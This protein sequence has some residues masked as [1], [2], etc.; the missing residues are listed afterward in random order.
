[1]SKFLTSE[2]TDV[3]VY[4][5]G[6]EI[7]RKVRVSVT[8]GKNSIALALVS[9][10]VDGESVKVNLSG[11]TVLVSAEYTVDYLH[12][13]DESERVKTLNENKKRTE[14]KIQRLKDKNET[15]AKEL[16]LLDHNCRTARHTL[17][18]KCQFDQKRNI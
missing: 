9:P 6:A 1:M 3:T 16:E 18:F 2:I 12:A 13:P 4:R 17:P 5:R 10:T 14:E 15:S 11:N 7:T 8:K